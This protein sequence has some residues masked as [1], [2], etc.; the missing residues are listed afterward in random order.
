MTSCG[1]LKKQ[2]RTI[3][4]CFGILYKYWEIKKFQDEFDL[5]QNIFPENCKKPLPAIL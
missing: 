4:N 3:S 1:V 5:R 2:S